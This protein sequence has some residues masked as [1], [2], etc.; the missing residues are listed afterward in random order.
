MLD[1]TKSFNDEQKHSGW[2][3]RLFPAFV[4]TAGREPA[5]L[6]DEVFNSFVFADN[7]SQ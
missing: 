7:E 5:R 6:P 3:W 2:D 4:I 1:I